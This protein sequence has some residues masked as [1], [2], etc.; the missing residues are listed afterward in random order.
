[1]REISHDNINSFLGACFETKPSF[2]LFKYCPK[3]SL[4][5][6][7]CVLCYSLVVIKYNK[8]PTYYYAKGS[9]LYRLILVG[10]DS[11][12]VNMYIPNSCNNVI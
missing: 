8:L 10:L 7:P 9:E 11:L 12:E 5:V 2:L 3:G 4:Q 1:M 6:S